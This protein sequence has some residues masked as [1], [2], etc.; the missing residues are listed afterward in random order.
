[1]L[2]NCCLDKN[3]DLGVGR[4]VVSKGGKVCFKDPVHTDNITPEKYM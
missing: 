1:M 2:L 4:V 3:I